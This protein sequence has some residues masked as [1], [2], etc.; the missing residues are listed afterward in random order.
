MTLIV[1]FGIIHQVVIPVALIAVDKPYV[2]NAHSF[3]RI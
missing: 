1:G 2:Y 3:S